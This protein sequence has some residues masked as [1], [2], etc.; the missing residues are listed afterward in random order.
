MCLRVTSVHKREC[1]LAP[2]RDHREINR[3]VEESRKREENVENM[4]RVHKSLVFPSRDT[5]IVRF[6]IH[7]S[8]CVRHASLRQ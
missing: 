3:T 8:V 6:P 1:L 5:Q 4:Y 7:V 2:N